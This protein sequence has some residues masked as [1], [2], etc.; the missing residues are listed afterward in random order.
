M[1]LNLIPCTE[2]LPHEQRTYPMYREP[3]LQTGN[4]PD[5]RVGLSGRDTLNRGTH[6]LAPAHEDGE[7]DEDGD[8]VDVVEAVHAV[9]VVAGLQSG[10]GGE[11]GDDGAD[12][13]R[14]T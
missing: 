14:E 10:V 4:L 5:G 1:Y 3:T 7:D 12:A 8:G 13:A 11:A 6:I 2:N 9:V